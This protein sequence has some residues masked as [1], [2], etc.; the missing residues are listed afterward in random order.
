MDMDPDSIDDS[1]RMLIGSFFT[2]EY[3]IESAAFFNPS[4]ME[5]PDQKEIG[6]G[7]LRVIF[8]FRATGEGHISSIVFRTGVL[9][10]DCNLSLEPT[11]KMLEEAEHIQRHVYQKESFAHKLDEML[12][13][14]NNSIQS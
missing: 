7:Q 3:S 6:P 8:S 9:D 10:R 2:L 4:I 14:G 13:A 5:H 1:R 12:G 11:G